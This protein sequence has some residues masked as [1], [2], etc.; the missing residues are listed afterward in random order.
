[1]FAPFVEAGLP[2]LMHSDGRIDKI[3]PDLVEIGLT[4]YN[5]V[6][7]EVTDHG[8]LHSTFGTTL[9]YYGGL[10]T[11]TVLPFGTPDEVRSATHACVAA[12]APEGTGLL[13]APSHRMMSDIPMQNVEA[14]L[15]AFADAGG[16]R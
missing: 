8:W 11:Q 15:E 12:L 14:M 9:A 13:L 4:V 1:M 10:S 6:Q 3:L 16:S 2:I 5:P 7:P